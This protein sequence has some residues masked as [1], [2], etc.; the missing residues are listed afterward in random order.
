[1]HKKD[2]HLNYAP[3]HQKDQHLNYAPKYSKKINMNQP[4]NINKYE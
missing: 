1:M 3:N 4:I 2:Q